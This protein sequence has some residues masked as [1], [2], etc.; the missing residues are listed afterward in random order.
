MVA[1]IRRH[2]C[3]KSI[4]PN[5]STTNTSANAIQIVEFIFPP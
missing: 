4:G 2:A 5:P 3:G 1:I